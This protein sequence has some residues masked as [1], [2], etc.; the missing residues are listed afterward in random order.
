MIEYVIYILQTNKQ[1]NKC[2]NLIL[3]IFISYGKLWVYIL[4]GNKKLYINKYTRDMTII[5]LF[6]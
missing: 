3:D 6:P 2:T 4:F 5:S 1:T